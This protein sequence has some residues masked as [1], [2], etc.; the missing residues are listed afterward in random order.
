M[1]SS[2]MEG[3]RAIVIGGGSGIGL[4]TARS[5]A[6]CGARV[7]IAGRTEDKLQNAALSLAET[8]LDVAWTRCDALVAGEVSAAVDTASED[9]KLHIA[10]VVPGGGSISPVL[11][12][13]DDQFS[14]EVDLN[15]RPV[16]LLLKFAGQAM[17]RAGGGSFVAISSS[18]AAFSARY[19]ASYSAGKAAVDQLVKVAANEL[20]QFGVRVN[21]VRPGMTRT[22]TTAAAFA[23]ESMLA[24]FIKG[25]P[26]ARGGEVADVA[27]AVK[28]LAGPDSS[29]VTGQCLSVDGGHTLRSFV[30]YG[31]I[32]D[33]PDQAQ[34]ATSRQIPEEQ[35]EPTQS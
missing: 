32:L 35:S 29:W 34:V 6:R 2:S 4:G 10:V 5:L 18:A 7:T 8:G 3:L 31:E 15:V 17:I 19:L 1:D 9:G 25:Q 13:G 27:E 21:S 24:E 14:R 12:Y 28:Y 11:L 23:N 20:G 30:D 26:L 22:P 16:Y 33:I